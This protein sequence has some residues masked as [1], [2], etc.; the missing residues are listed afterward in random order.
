MLKGLAALAMPP[1]QVILLGFS[2]GAS[3]VLEYAAR[4]PRRYGAVVGLSGGLV[5]PEDVPRDYDGSLRGTPVFIACGEDDPHLPHRRVEET[6]EALGS[7]GAEVTTRVYPDLGHAINDDE[8][9]AVKKLIE[10]IETME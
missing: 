5:G 10:R 3:L 6:A 4:N 1:E 7:L 9:R 8:I 2:Q